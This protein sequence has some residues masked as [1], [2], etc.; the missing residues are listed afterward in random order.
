MGQ[1]V[2]NAMKST[3]H[4]N[5]C[6]ISFIRK[7]I[8]YIVGGTEAYPGSWPWIV[9]LLV[10]GV[11]M[12]AGTIL[13]NDW[14]LTAAHCFD[15]AQ[16]RNASLWNV[17]SGKHHSNCT[18]TTE[19]EWPVSQIVIHPGYVA[20]T[21]EN[22]IALL[23]L[24]KP[25]T[26]NCR[27]QPICLPKDDKPLKTGRFCKIAGWGMTFGKGS[28]TALNELTL[29]VINGSLCGSLEYYGN[30]YHEENMVCLGY[31]EGGLDACNGDSGGPMVCNNNGKWILSGVTSWGL[32]CAQPKQPGVYTRIRPFMTWIKKYLNANENGIVG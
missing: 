13:N 30:R 22:D 28:R 7:R 29:P 31:P 10:S 20:P 27:T 3:G 11:R 9:M 32:G 24:S 14:V 5:E 1:N 16:L 18:D 4:T 19:Q 6:G 26:Y 12:C 23:K 25:L 17:T 21:N 15:Y 8:S 2:C